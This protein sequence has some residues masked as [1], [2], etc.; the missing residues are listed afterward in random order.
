MDTPQLADI[1]LQ[2]WVSLSVVTRVPGHV[3]HMDLG[4]IAALEPS[5][6]ILVPVWKMGFLPGW[7]YTHPLGPCFLTAEMSLEGRGA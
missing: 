5:P 2:L 7:L 6:E 3:S 1:K 4:G